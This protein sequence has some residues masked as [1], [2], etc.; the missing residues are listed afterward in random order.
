MKP[1][2]KTSRDQ[3]TARYGALLLALSI[4]ACTEVPSGRLQD[5]VVPDP[6]PS[7]PSRLPT[8]PGWAAEARIGGI[9]LDMEM[10][11]GEIRN[12]LASLVSQNASVALIRGP[13]DG[14]LDEVA[15][16]R[17]LGFLN[18]VACLGHELGLRVALR[19]PALEMVGPPAT[20]SG[21]VQRGM[22]GQHNWRLDE[23]GMIETAWMCPNGPFRQLAFSRAGRL[24]GTGIDAMVVSDP[25]LLGESAPWPCTCR[26]CAKAFESWSL[27]EGHWG[28]SGL[29]MPREVDFNDPSFKAWV[30][31]RHQSLADFMEGL[32][33]A[34]HSENP[35]TWVF[36]QDHVLDHLDATETGLDGAF[37][38]ASGRF[39]RLWD[40]E[41]VSNTS[42]MRWATP[43]DFT[44]RIAML[45][46]G[47]S[48]DEPG[49]SWA[50]SS[51]FD[52]MDS[53]LSMGAL[54]AIGHAPL[55]T[56]SRSLDDS[57]GQGF[58]R[59]WFLAGASRP[60]LMSGHP[61]EARVGLWHSSATR[62]HVDHGENGGRFGYY[63]TATPPIEDEGWWSDDHS[64]SC[65]LMPHLGEWRGAA[66][67]LIQMG[68]PFV[69]LVAGSGPPPDTEGLTAIWLPAVSALSDPEIERLSRFVADGGFL[70]ATGD[71]PGTLDE[72]GR[73]RKDNPMLRIFEVEE[74]GLP[75]DQV[76]HHGSGIA[77]YRGESLGRSTFESL[78]EGDEV[79]RVFRHIERW[80][81]IHVELDWF[82][83]GPRWV[84]LE[85]VKETDRRHVLYVLNFCGLQQPLCEM[86]GNFD[87]VVRV[88]EGLKVS[89]VNGLQ[90]DGTI[91]EPRLTRSGNSTW[92]VGVRV[93]VVGIF[94][95]I[96]EPDPDW[97]P[98]TGFGPPPFTDPIREAVARSGLQFV[99]DRLRNPSL[100]E[101]LDAGVRS[102]VRGELIVTSEDMGL[103]L[104]TAACM[105]EP[106]AWDSAFR[107]VE[108]VML[109]RAFQLPKRVLSSRTGRPVLQRDYVGGHWYD[110][111]RPV[112]D[113]RLVRGLLEGK[114]RF[115]RQQGGLLAHRILRGLQWTSLVSRED[116][117]SV[118]FPG[119]PG[120]LVGG[121]WKWEG[122]D[123]P[124]L[125]PPARSTGKGE[126]DAD[127]IPLEHQDLLAMSRGAL[128][129]VRW[130]DLI[131]STT[132]FLLDGEITE[133]GPSI[134]LFW[135]GMEGFNAIWTG[136]HESQET[137]HGRHLNTIQVIRTALHLARASNLS[138]ELL[139]DG[140]RQ[141]ARETAGR[142]LQFLRIFYQAE[143]RIP[144]YLTIW[145]TDVPDCLNSLLPDC[146]Y[147]DIDN[148][149]EGDIRIYSLAARLALELGDREFA[150]TLI[151]R[152][153]LFDRNDDPADPFHGQLG[154]SSTHQ[155]DA[156]AHDVLE[157]IL[158]LCEEAR[159]QDR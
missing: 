78:T 144:E 149:F 55:E 14:Y 74:E 85:V 154:V 66:H 110:S 117:G 72:F 32:T 100:P 52:Q 39:A 127:I 22:D 25:L 155:H 108:Q 143:D 138:P 1:D 123:E 35:G 111:N 24:A 150:G 71:F 38:K 93:G 41:N 59:L 26:Y 17:V 98:D 49:P 112:D 115:D 90:W 101:P 141:R 21:W 91:Q 54:L 158:T 136:D 7:C 57:V 37:I 121:S 82:V 81:R 46:W 139:D 152:R 75:L 42:G 153:I 58:R 70:L 94:E 126:M 83:K 102:Q 19:V 96:L 61:R 76:R 10:S 118:S 103:L 15:F 148:R 114:D 67:S 142:T 131:E 120:G 29:H 130:R 62:D 124:S 9:R 50:V 84:H 80:L 23:Q 147:H 64:N 88:P 65:A 5:A 28:Q 16:H 20:V 45:K 77:V 31:W 68:I 89:F 63:A 137:I 79:S 30:H 129:D 116:T 11:D 69:P 44:S 86:P 92:V 119:Y 105:D 99:L 151:R 140:K 97:A 12:A 122:S 132:D 18:R 157:A 106:R 51:G 146:L 6:Y 134:G 125:S 60:D 53:A 13:L 128:R 113:F 27:D 4:A 2:R 34:V 8:N 43:E 145:G 73:H 3:G 156:V 104:R 133:A 40:V 95:L 87:I 56:R 109:D 47:R 48:L 135:N 159:A 107:Y 36:L 33:D